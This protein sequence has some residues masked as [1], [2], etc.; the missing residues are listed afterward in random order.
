MRRVGW[1]D[2]RRNEEV[3]MGGQEDWRDSGSAG[4]GRLERN[5]MGWFG[6]KAMLN[7]V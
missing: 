4:A 3:G 5:A 1:E 2:K 7:P 6:S